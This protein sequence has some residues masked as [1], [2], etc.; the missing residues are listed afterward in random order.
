[1]NNLKKTLVFTYQSK[2]FHENTEISWFAKR[3]SWEA[4][5]AQGPPGP[6]APQGPN[7]AH[8]RPTIRAHDRPAIGSYS[9]IESYSTA[10][11]GTVRGSAIALFTLV[12]TITTNSSKHGS[13]RLQCNL[14]YCE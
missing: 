2:L 7:R 11:G 6:W 13:L 8:D 12:G 1:M 10:I 3:R 9:S 14:K 5:G 4:L